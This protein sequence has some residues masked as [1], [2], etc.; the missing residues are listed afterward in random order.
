MPFSSLLLIWLLN[1]DS[2]CCFA[3][4]FNLHWF[5]NF[6][7]DR[8]YFHEFLDI[9]ENPTFY[10]LIKLATHKIIIRVMV[11]LKSH[12]L[13]HIRRAKWIVRVK[14]IAEAQKGQCQW[15]TKSENR[16]RIIMWLKYTKSCQHVLCQNQFWGSK[17]FCK[18]LTVTVN[19]GTDVN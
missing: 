5:L 14:W 4:V 19:L 10:I 2:L 8:T 7:I 16:Q 13:L 6:E 15:W 12:I 9:S 17:M 11:Y 18:F 3:F 1:T